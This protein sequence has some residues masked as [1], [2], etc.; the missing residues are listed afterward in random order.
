MPRNKPPRPLVTVHVVGGSGTGTGDVVG[1]AGATRATPTIHVSQVTTWDDFLTA[2]RDQVGIAMVT[3]AG[4]RQ[5][6]VDA[7]IAAGTLQTV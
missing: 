2:V 5:A 3:D 7:L 1:P 4:G 6:F